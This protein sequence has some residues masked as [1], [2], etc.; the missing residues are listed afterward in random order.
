MATILG[1]VSIWTTIQRKRCTSVKVRVKAMQ[2][3]VG[4]HFGGAVSKKRDG[5]E[6]ESFYMQ[7]CMPLQWNWWRQKLWATYVCNSC[8]KSCK[9]QYT[10]HAIFWDVHCLVGGEWRYN[11]ISTTGTK[12]KHN[13]S[14]QLATL[15]VSAIVCIRLGCTPYFGMHVQTFREC[16]MELYC[17]IVCL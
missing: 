11:M 5:L 1:V 10:F 14:C 15:F 13:P 17:G 9:H 7:I 12:C 3:A 6:T 4:D 2:S 8:P 16:H